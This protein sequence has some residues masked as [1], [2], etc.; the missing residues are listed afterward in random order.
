MNFK[1]LLEFVKE[2]V[3]GQKLVDSP[4]IIEQGKGE[5]FITKNKFKY[6]IFSE[7]NPIDV[8]IYDSNNKEECILFHSNILSDKI[9]DIDEFKHEGRAKIIINY[10]IYNNTTDEYRNAQ[11][12][13]CA[14]FGDHPVILSTTEKFSCTLY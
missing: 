4:L 8:Y 2:S 5:P 1:N 12:V 13:V 6:E 9:N 11:F 7:F 3:E 14:T 10:N